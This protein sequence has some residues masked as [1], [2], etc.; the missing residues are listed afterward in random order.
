MRRFGKTATR[1]ILNQQLKKMQEE[2]GDSPSQ[3]DITEIEIKAK[4]KKWTEAAQKN[5]IRS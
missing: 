3:N 5:L 4:A 2:L 1:L